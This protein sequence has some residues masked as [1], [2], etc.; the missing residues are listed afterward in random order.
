MKVESL[1]CFYPIVIPAK[2]GIQS[3]S[4]LWRISILALLFLQYRIW[5]IFHLDGFLTDFVFSRSN[6]PAL[7]RSQLACHSRESGNPIIQSDDNLWRI[8]ILAL[9]FLQYRIW[10]IFHLDGF[11]TDFVFN[12]PWRGCK[13]RTELWVWSNIIVTFLTTPYPLLKRGSIYAFGQKP[14]IPPLRE[15]SSKARRWVF[16]QTPLPTYGR[17]P[18]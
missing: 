10:K 12:P 5:K 7:E 11:L 17:T 4:N 6:A 3:S 9:L 8:S 16:V 14:K 18:L 2:A 15:V 1:F 13:I